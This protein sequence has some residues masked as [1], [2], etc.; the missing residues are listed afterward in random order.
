MNITIK[1]SKKRRYTV[2]EVRM[3]MKTLEEN[4]YKKIYNA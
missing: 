4:R 2:K 3:W 1:E